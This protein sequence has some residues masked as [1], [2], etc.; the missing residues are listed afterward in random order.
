VPPLV[1]VVPYSDM[2]TQLF[3]TESDR[4]GYALGNVVTHIHH[5]G[6]TAI[7]GIQA[8]PII[9][10]LIEVCETLELDIRSQAMRELGYEV[11][12]EFG[13][14]GRRYYRKGNV[15][16][17][18]THHLHAFQVDDSNIARHLAF[19]DYMIAHSAVA[20]EYGS[21]KQ[22]LAQAHSDDFEAY[23]D[24]KDEFI[25]VHEKRAVAWWPTQFNDPQAGQ[26][27]GGAIEP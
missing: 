10:I 4:I 8:K 22:E 3:Q 5:I 19:R 25:K 26:L 18:K 12:G 17:I 7:P 14:P 16:G 11:L 6:S 24:G 1:N 2:W 20:R 13:I 23:I 15:Q 9:D 27:N 21:L